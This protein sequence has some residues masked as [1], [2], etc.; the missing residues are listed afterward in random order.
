MCSLYIDFY[1]RPDAFVKNR[2]DREQVE[3]VFFGDDIPISRNVPGE[4][5]RPIVPQKDEILNPYQE[6]QAG[7]H[8][9]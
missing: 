6:T 3:A 4:G 9:W 7:R 5:N 1:Q 8:L 2:L